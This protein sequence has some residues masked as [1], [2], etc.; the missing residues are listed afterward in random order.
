M[1]RSIF[2]SPEKHF[3]EVVEKQNAVEE[4]A[5]LVSSEGKSKL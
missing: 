4:Y 5:R 3:N 2:V 1:K